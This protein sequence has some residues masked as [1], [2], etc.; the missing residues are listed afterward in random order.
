MPD[1]CELLMLAAPYRDEFGQLY[2]IFEPCALS[3]SEEEKENVK[4]AYS[5]A[6]SKGLPV[7]LSADF[8]DWNEVIAELDFLG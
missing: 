4:A 2:R 6:L 8:K 7:V 5:I 1:E 3:T